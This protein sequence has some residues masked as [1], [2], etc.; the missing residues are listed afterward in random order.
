MKTKFKVILYIVAIA[1]VITALVLIFNTKTIDTS[2]FPL[3]CL[4]LFCLVLPLWADS[5]RDDIEDVSMEELIYN[6]EHEVKG[7]YI[8]KDG[9][10]YIAVIVDDV[11]T[12][13]HFETRR[14]CIKWI[15]KRSKE[16]RK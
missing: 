10:K 13:Q 6:V 7:K 3:F 9:N 16:M 8:E 1:S 15:D 2:V 5:I 14:D 12:F 11:T 4:G